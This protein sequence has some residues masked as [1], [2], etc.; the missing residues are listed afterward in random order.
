MGKHCDME[1]QHGGGLPCLAN[2]VAK[3]DGEILDR[4]AGIIAAHRPA[5]LAA[6]AFVYS[7][8]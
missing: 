3:R 4:G 1:V 5:G 8:G 2:L 6:Q 7:S